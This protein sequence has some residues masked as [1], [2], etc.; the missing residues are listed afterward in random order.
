MKVT[1]FNTKIKKK[2]LFIATTIVV[3]ITIIL[4]F[5]ISQR[6]IEYKNLDIEKIYIQENNA[7]KVHL[8]SNKNTICTLEYQNVNNELFAKVSIIEKHFSKITKRNNI[9]KYDAKNW[10]LDSRFSQQILYNTHYNIESTQD[11]V[12]SEIYYTDCK[13]ET[14][15]SA[16]NYPCI[17][18]T[19]LMFKC[20]NPEININNAPCVFEFNSILKLF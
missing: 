20:N 15:Q 4:L 2:G 7:N 14:P 16:S 3:I 13:W 9:L 6:F 11:M 18:K 12:L 19:T 17:S 8:F 10:P 5:F 1:N